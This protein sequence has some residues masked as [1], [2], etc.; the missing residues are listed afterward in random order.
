MGRHGVFAGGDDGGTPVARLLFAFLGAPVLW[1]LHLATVYLIVTVDCIS[2]WNGGARAVVLATLLFAAGCGA[3]GWT[4]WRL[5]QRLGARPPEPPERDW[6]RF[7]LLAGMGASLLF[8]VAVLLEGAA[9][10][11][12]RM[13][14]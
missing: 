14:A 10:F 6:I 12:V 8:G 7:M 13:C 4:G 9:P 2:P 11:L 3:A 5:W 1:A